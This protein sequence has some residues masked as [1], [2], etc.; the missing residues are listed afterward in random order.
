MVRVESAGVTVRAPLRQCERLRCRKHVKY[1][2]R[3]TS[4]KLWHGTLVQ[5][6]LLIDFRVTN[7]HF[8]GCCGPEFHRV[9]FPLHHGYVDI[10]TKENEFLFLTPRN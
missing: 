5:F 10:T 8:I 1:F 9:P 7:L 4:N 6:D 2:V 3:W